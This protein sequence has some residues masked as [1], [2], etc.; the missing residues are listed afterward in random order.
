MSV[1]YQKLFLHTFICQYAKLTNWINDLIHL[2]RDYSMDLCILVYEKEKFERK[3][4]FFCPNLH[5]FVYSARHNFKA[6]LII[7]SKKRSLVVGI[8]SSA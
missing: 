3:S 7:N 8:A 4:E 2:Y 6:T 5:K 1:D